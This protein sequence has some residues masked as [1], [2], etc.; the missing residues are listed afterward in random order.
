MEH[1][2]NIYT[3]MVEDGE[4]EDFF[5]AQHVDK[6]IVGKE[7][8]DIG[9]WQ[10]LHLKKG[11]RTGQIGTLEEEPC[12]LFPKTCN[13]IRNL[14]SVMWLYNASKCPDGD[15]TLMPS[16]QE[17]AEQESEFVFGKPAGLVAM[18]RLKQ[19]QRVP[20]HSGPTNQ[21]LK[22]QLGID[23]PEGVSAPRNLLTITCSCLFSLTIV[24]ELENRWIFVS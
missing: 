5:T 7:M 24:C 13:L 1:R 15:C 8:V 19:G 12:T 22:C 23:I 3:Q 18:Y 2:Y 14:N 16:P 9:A 17:L 21:R 10:Y 4:V 11:E 6:N 20:L